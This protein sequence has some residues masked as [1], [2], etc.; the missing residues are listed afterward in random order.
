MPSKNALFTVDNE[1]LS[2]NYNPPEKI[3]IDGYK[4][5]ESVLIEGTARSE[6]NI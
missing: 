2:K 1:F 6:S 4:R 5:P 3:T